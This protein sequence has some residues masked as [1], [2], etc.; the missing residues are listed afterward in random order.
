[1]TPS[2][3]MHLVLKCIRK[4]GSKFHFLLEERISLRGTSFL[5]PCFLMHLV[6]KCIRKLGSKMHFFE[7]VKDFSDTK[8]AR[9]YPRCTS[10]RRGTSSQ[11]AYLHLRAFSIFD[12]LRPRPPPVCRGEERWRAYAFGA[13]MHKEMG[14][15]AFSLRGMNLS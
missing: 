2:F 12:F 15:R 8:H 13:K 9:K 3:L 7:V 5:T 11:T 4:L 14:A 10:P 1:M 6:L